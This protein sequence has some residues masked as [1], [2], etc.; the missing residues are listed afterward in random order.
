MKYTK[1]EIEELSEKAVLEII[2]E[3]A[4]L[5]QQLDVAMECLEIYALDGQ[6]LGCLHARKALGNIKALEGQE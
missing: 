6:I 4:T 3:N 2:K 5:K 1:E